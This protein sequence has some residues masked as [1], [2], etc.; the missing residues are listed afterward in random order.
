M[1]N[2]KLQ[3]MVHADNIATS[4]PQLSYSGVTIESVQRTDNE[5]YL[6]INLLLDKDVK[7]GIFEIAFKH[8]EKTISSYTYELKARKPNSAQRQG[9]SSK[10][11]VYLITPDRFANGDPSNDSIDGLKEGVNRL[12]KGGRHGGDLQG[13][14]DN[15][16]YIT[17]MGFTQIWT[18]PIM[19]NDMQTHSYHGYS[20]TDYYRVDPR[21]GSN[22]L[23][24]ELSEKA[25]GQGIGIIQD[26]ILNHIGSEHWWM[27]DKPS[28]DWI[29]N[30]GEFSPTSH[31]R[32]S[33]H[34]PHA[35]KSDITRF[36]DGWFVPT[37]PDLNQRNPLLATY[38]IQNSIWWVEY[39]QLSG[40][41]VDTYS[42]SDMR[43]LSNWTRQIMQ[44]YP[45]LNVV[46]EEWSV[47]PSITSF[48]Q[49]G[50][51]RHSDYQSWL[52]SV[53]DF[54]TQV[55]LINALTKPK[56]W[57]TG[58][59]E[60]YE[61]LASDF[62]Y[63]DPY[64]LVVFADNHDMSRIFSQL[65]E[66]L[67][68]FKMAMSYVLTT[69]GI[70]QVFYGTEILMANPGT[71]DHG[72]I[73][74]DFPGGWQD[75]SSSGFS[76]KGLSEQQ[77]QIQGFFRKLLNW[78]KSST[79]ITQGKLAHYTPQ[80]GLYVYF[81]YTQEQRVMV[82]L[83]KNDSITDLPLERYTEMLNGAK[84]AKNVLTDQ[85]ISL[86][87]ALSIAAKSALILELQ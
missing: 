75:D 38:L 1:V 65:D 68:L 49:K 17:D 19:E 42:Y 81:R 43:F 70:P 36:N 21:Y 22:E 44:E 60:L 11:V 39:A 84:T 25:A 86:G 9:F 52:P 14:I 26:V 24:V 62:V 16:D 34:D 50:S 73:R 33:L 61:S 12:S 7:P 83:N 72:I 54:P 82:I 66:D 55:K 46:G 30:N 80:N 28:A 76:G 29:N 56:S 8:G 37:M 51:V 27:K 4:S 48:W 71:E 23:Y 74:S 41:R 85:H 58:L 15:L 77:I 78:R 59:R 79:A 40:L 6:F 5:N 87:Q 20:T 47:N 64:N 57:A 53:M 31:M 32:E 69:R 3:L 13:I 2:P 10:D 45:N 63:G 35:V 18:M 67:D